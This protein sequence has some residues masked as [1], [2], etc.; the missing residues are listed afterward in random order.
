MTQGYRELFGFQA[1]LA[2][3]WVQSV[4]A[5]AQCYVALLDPRPDLAV[6][7]RSVQAPYRWWW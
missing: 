3:H 1:A 7:A 2:E 4:C 5:V 6:P